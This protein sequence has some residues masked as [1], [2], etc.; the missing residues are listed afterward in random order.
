VPPDAPARAVW[1]A[2]AGVVVG[3]ATTLDGSGS[4]GDGALSCTWSYENS[5]GST[6][7]DTETGCRISKTFTS[8]G[9]KYVRLIVRDA[10]GDTNSLK[11]SF[12]VAARSSRSRGV[13]ASASAAE[14][15]ATSAYAFE[16]PFG[17][18]LD[19]AAGGAAGRL[20]GADRTRAGRFGRA[21]R[22]DGNGAYAALARPVADSGLSLSAWVR[23]AAGRRA[24]GVFAARS[25]ALAS[26]RWSHLALVWD[27]TTVRVYVDGRR[28]ETQRRSGTL[29]PGGPVIVG[30]GFRGTVD[31]VRI[32]GRLVSAREIRG[33]MRTGIASRR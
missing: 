25:S 24:S 13:S 4:T 9:T 19:A 27:G 23:P 2:P 1:T 17:S 14:A 32:Y 16:E 11:R 7:W 8:T 21:L 26:R 28:T 3:T 6:V 10:D 20:Y 31:E 29:V 15:A 5:S 22:F 30:R 12:N 18:T 33:V